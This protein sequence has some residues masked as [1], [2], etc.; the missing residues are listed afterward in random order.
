MTKPLSGKEPPQENAV[1][2]QLLAKDR[3][4]LHQAVAMPS[5]GKDLTE[6]DVTPLDLTSGAKATTGVDLCLHQNARTKG[7]FK[8]QSDARAPACP[9]VWL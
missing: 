5:E 3:F 2:L 8:S 4:S 6:Q 1:V 9:C 7:A